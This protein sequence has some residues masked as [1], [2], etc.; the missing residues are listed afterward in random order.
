MAARAP[1]TSAEW[2]TPASLNRVRLGVKPGN[3]PAVVNS[4]RVV[5]AQ[6]GVTTPNGTFWHRYNLGSNAFLGDPGAPDFVFFTVPKN[7]VRVLVPLLEFNL[8]EE[9]ERLE[10]LVH[11]YSAPKHC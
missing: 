8:E 3:N 10:S 1:L 6:L 11:G 4:L 5:D 9:R 7:P 2:S